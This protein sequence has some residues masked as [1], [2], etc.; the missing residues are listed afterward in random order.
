M[1]SR[2]FRLI[3]DAAVAAVALSLFGWLAVAVMHRETTAFDAAARDA[4]H[5]L[6][7]PGM[8]WVMRGVTELGGGFFLWP[9]GAL[10]V[11]WL[12]MSGRRRDA[13]LLTVAVVGANAF[14]EAM[15]LVFQRARPGPWFGYPRPFTYSFPS[16][17]AFVSYCFYLALAAILI[18][19]HWRLWKKFAAWTAALALTSLIGFS[20]VYLGVHFPTD[21]LAGY[22][23]AIAWSAVIRAAHQAWWPPMLE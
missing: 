15:K 17:H 16:G 19:E 5:A 22:A 23:A 10:L 18:P 7:S 13:V 14:G 6:A 20:R 21:V 3:R 2:N 4:V 9:L 1:F 11:L 12:A 8:T